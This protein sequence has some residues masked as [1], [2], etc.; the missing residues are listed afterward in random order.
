MGATWRAVE[1]GDVGGVDGV[2]QVAD[3]EDAGAL[4][5]R[6]GVDE[7]AEGA[8]VELDAAGAGEFVVGDPVAGEDDGVAVEVAARSGVEVF[9]RHGLD[10][11]PADDA[12]TR[13]RVVR[14][15]E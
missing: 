12:V 8:G 11:V 4:V 6:R 10:A 7:R 9:D 5:R 13:V 2:Q 3:R 14:G 15:L 1:G